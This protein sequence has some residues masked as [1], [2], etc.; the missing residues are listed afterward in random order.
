MMKSYLDNI[1][2]IEMQMKI[3][4][5]ESWQNLGTFRSLKAFLPHQFLRRKKLK[6]NH[7]K[8]KVCAKSRKKS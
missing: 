4:L 8:Q 1:T 6:Q 3:K 2:K 5:D 7:C